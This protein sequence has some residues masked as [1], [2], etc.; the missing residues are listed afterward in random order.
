MHFQILVSEPANDQTR[1]ANV[2]GFCAEGIAFITVC[3]GMVKRY[4]RTGTA[5]DID[6]T[7]LKATRNA[8]IIV[9]VE[10]SP[11]DLASIINARGLGAKAPG[12]Q[13]L[14]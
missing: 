11:D 12:I 2:E 1:L 8:I 7:A 3:G 5:T 9:D 14:V 10:K 6:E 13:I 4:E